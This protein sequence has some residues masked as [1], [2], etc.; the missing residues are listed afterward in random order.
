MVSISSPIK[1]LRYLLFLYIGDII[2]I[3]FPGHSLKYL[4]GIYKRYGWP[5]QPW[6]IP[7]EITWHPQEI[8]LVS[9]ALASKSLRYLLQVLTCYPHVI[10]LASLGL[11]SS[12][13]TYF[14]SIGHRL[15]FLDLAKSSVTYMSSTKDMEDLTIL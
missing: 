12:S 1:S 13:Y 11:A 5:H 3:N 9:L 7:Q 14:L 6:R 2:G 15:A 8:C 4:L 10:W